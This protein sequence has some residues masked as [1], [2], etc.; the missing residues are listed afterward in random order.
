[1]IALPGRRDAGRLRLRRAHRGR[2][3]HHRRAG[4]TAGWCRWSRRSRT[5]TSSR[6]FT[7]KAPTAGADPRLAAFVKTPRARNKIRQWFTKERREEAIER[8][9]DAI[10]KPMRK[11]GLPLQ[12]LHVPRVA[13]AG[14]RG[15]TATPTSRR[16]TRRSARATSR[17]RPSSARVIELA[18]RRG[19]RGRGPRRGR[20]DHR[21]RATGPRSRSGR[22]GR[23][24]QGR[25]RRAGSS[26]RRC[27]TPV[28]GDP[29]LGFV[30]A[31]VGVSVHRVDCTN[32][33]EPAAPAGAAGRRRVGTDRPVDASWS[34]SRSRRSTA[35]G[36]SPTSRGCSPTTTSTS[37]R[38][39]CRPPATGSP[40]PGSP[41]RWPTRQAPRHTSSAP[42]AGRR[43]L[44]RLPRHAVITAHRFIM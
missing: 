43:R 39:L 21:P 20:H 36:C 42:S 31:A 16:S 33:D 1:M 14:R 9:K 15:T 23:H 34:T 19:G 26:S 25:A 30:T 12:R 35:P 32:A 41:S 5:A 27:C 28:P 37:C 8:G 44:R 11:Q 7:S 10:A 3:P 2:P 4:S 17:R 24:R 38:H 29:I 18:R 40:R 13:D 6:C 22:P